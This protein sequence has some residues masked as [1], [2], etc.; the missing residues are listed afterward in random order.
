MKYETPACFLVFILYRSSFILQTFPSLQTP[1]PRPRLFQI[2]NPKSK[3]QNLFRVACSCLL[4]GSGIELLFSVSQSL[5]IQ[6]E[7]QNPKSKIQTSLLSAAQKPMPPPSRVDPK[8]Q[9]LLDHTIQ[10]L[11]GS[12]FLRFKTLTTRGRSYSISDGATAGFVTF[13]SEVE[14]PDK[15]RFAY[16]FGKKKPV[17]LVNNGDRAWELDRF[18]ITHQMPEQVRRWKVTNHYGLENLLRLRIHEPSLLIQDGG[19]D[20]VDNLAT[21]VVDILDAN[22]VQVK[23]Y[24][25]KTTFLPVRVVYRVQNPE[26]HEWD[27]YGDVYGDY[28]K[29]QEIQ[30]PMHITRF[31]NGER[32]LEIFR[33][34][35]QYDETYRP[36]HFEPI[37]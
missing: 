15:R 29:V 25:S 33:N 31:L 22:Q 4:L 18:G 32:I 30:T 36:N 13:E 17:V 37:G 20:F 35:V 19:A 6:L 8:A 11:G 7:I 10:A 34:S 24:I 14:Y 12:A 26:T 2:R 23:L 21:R 3:I 1:V 16:G 9:E 27:E 5:A 28:Q